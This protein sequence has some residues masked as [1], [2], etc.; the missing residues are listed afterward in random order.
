MTFYD[1]PSTDNHKMHITDHLCC[2]TKIL[3]NFFAMFLSGIVQCVFVFQYRGEI[4][5][6]RKL[7][8]LS[9][10][11]GV[12]D[13]DSITLCPFVV[14]AYAPVEA[15]VNSQVGYWCCHGR[16]VHVFVFGYHSVVLC[17]PRSK[18]QH[19]DRKNH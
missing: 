6:D 8:H 10:L 5:N 2:V 18:K 15:F 1:D 11:E 12:C 7:S 3:F 9:K 4:K 13:S 19:E 14:V 16:N 17:K